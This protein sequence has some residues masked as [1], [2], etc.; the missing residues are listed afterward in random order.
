M[1]EEAADEL[2]CREDQLAGLAGVLVAISEGAV[3][4]VV[5]E[6]GEAARTT[7]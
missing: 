5:H 7:R 1:L 3:V 4:V 6:Y 2:L